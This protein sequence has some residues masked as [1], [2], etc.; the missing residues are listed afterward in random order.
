MVKAIMA[1]YVGTRSCI[2]TEAG[3][4]K[5]FGIG[6]GVHQTSILSTVLF[7]ILMDEAT[8]EAGKGVLGNLYMQI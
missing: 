3:A 8:R 2:K 5:D 1:L 7:I 6:V 4:S